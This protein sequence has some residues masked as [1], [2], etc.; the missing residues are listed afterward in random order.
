MNISIIGRRRE[1]I[2]AAIMY[3]VGALVTAF[4]PDL[5]VMVIGRLVY[6]IGIGLVIY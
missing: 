3:L 2:T 4:A 6:G 1:L 5:V